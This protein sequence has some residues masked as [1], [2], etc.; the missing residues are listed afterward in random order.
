ML[1]ETEQPIQEIAELIQQVKLADSIYETE[2]RLS[3]RTKVVIPVSL[4]DFEGSVAHGFSR[5]I[6]E[7][8][9]CLV[10]NEPVEPY[11]TS[12]LRLCRSDGEITMVRAESVWSKAFG[13]A[14]CISGWRFL[15][16]A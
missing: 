8:G 14:H 1:L 15:G 6:S 9:I 7:T 5:N 3:K 13:C 11:T 10:T 12:E 2:N 16:L 4:F